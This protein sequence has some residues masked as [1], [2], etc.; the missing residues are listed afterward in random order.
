[1]IAWRIGTAIAS[2][3]S[4]RDEERG[5][6]PWRDDAAEVLRRQGRSR[7]ANRAIRRLRW[8]LR[9]LVRPRRG[10]GLGNS[11]LRHRAFDRPVSAAVEDAG[12]PVDHQLALLQLDQVV[13]QLEADALVVDQQLAEGE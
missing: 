12:A 10:V 1:M 13:G 11:A 3:R 4:R 8:R 9:C 7:S 6:T 2:G 5:S